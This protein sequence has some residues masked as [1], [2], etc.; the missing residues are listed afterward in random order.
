[1]ITFFCNPS[2]LESLLWKTFLMVILQSSVELWLNFVTNHFYI[3]LDPP[4]STVEY[5]STFNTETPP[6]EEIIY[7]RVPGN[8]KI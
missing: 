6:S 1:M 5:S 7:T 3:I 4:V 8:L 2:V